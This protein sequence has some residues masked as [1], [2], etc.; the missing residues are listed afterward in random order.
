MTWNGLNE[1]D[2]Q[3]AGK[4]DMEVKIRIRVSKIS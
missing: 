2:I 1:P 3:I 4:I